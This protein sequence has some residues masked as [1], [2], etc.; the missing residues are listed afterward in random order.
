MGLEVM[1]VDV[2]GLRNSFYFERIRYCGRC[3]VYILE[4]KFYGGGICSFCWLFIE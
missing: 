1:D 3:F 4:R 2:R